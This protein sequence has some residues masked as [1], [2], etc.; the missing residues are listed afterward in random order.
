MLTGGQVS[1]RRIG[2]SRE[3][4]PWASATTLLLFF[5]LPQWSYR[6]T[7]RY[8]PRGGSGLVIVVFLRLLVTERLQCKNDA[9]VQNQRFGTVS[10]KLTLIH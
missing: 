2:P 6:T 7:W 8:Y 1:Q 4:H 9:H 10:S 5:G 3:R